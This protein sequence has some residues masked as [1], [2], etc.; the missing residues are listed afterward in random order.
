MLL[1]AN[2]MLLYFM[3]D[4]AY[5]RLRMLLSKLIAI[6]SGQGFSMSHTNQWI[7]TLNIFLVIPNNFIGNCFSKILV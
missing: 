2:Q 4:A 3:I 5:I 6:Q 1:R 7:I